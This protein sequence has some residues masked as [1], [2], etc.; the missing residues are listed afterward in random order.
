[1]VGSG[2]KT[3]SHGVVASQQRKCAE[4]RT[5]GRFSGTAAIFLFDDERPEEQV[6]SQSEVAL[7]DGV[8]G[9]G[10]QVG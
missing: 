4:V 10:C 2:K 7:S 5:V 1:M 9:S 3:D 6:F 8:E